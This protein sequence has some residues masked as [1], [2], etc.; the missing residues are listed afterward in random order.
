MDHAAVRG[1]ENRTGAAMHTVLHRY[2]LMM[3]YCLTGNHLA[4]S[5]INS[6]FGAGAQYSA[7]GPAHDRHKVW[8]AEQGLLQMVR[9]GDLN[10]KRALSASMGISTG[11]PVRG[12]ALR[13]VRRASL[14]LPRWYAPSRAGET[15]RKPPL[16]DSY[17]Q[18]TECQ[19]HGFEPLALMMYDDFVRRVHK[20]RTNP[21]LNQQVQ[22][23]GLH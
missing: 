22:V 4:I 13:Q 11:V 15:R 17:I 10:Y 12:D 9:T 8:M 3:H 18:S 21:H 5:D 2:A 1:V 14:C 19:D 23:R 16:G 20:C 7:T 6:G